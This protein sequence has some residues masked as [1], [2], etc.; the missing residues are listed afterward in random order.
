MENAIRWADEMNCAVTVCNTD[1]VI[2]YM[3]EKAKK[4]F[5]KYGDW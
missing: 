2:F 3:N 4:T 1:G 5:A